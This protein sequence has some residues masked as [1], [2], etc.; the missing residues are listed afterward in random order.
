MPS[1]EFSL[2]HARRGFSDAEAYCR[3]GWSWPTNK[4]LARTDALNSRIVLFT[5]TW[6]VAI[7]G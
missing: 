5:I 4:A 3:D 6:F 7:P 1:I 2:F